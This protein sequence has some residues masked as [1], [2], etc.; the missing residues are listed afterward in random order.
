M[1]EIAVRTM[2]LEDVNVKLIRALRPTGWRCIDITEAA[3]QSTVAHS[4]ETE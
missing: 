3:T 4:L 2:P 1:D